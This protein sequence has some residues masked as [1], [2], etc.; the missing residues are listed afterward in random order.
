LSK[1]YNK[2]ISQLGLEIELYEAT[3]HSFG[4]QRINEG[5]PE[6]LLR[7]WF[8]HC[9]SEMTRKYAKLRV[10]DAFR[11]IE[12]RKKNVVELKTASEDRQ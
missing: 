7:E 4:T 2:A 11:E 1:I 8:G 5:V 9:N 6:N 3:K 12:N 10:V